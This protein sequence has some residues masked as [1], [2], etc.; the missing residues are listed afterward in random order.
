MELLSGQAVDLSRR[1]LSY[2]I[3]ACDTTHPGSLNGL[4][5]RNSHVPG[6]I[7]TV[8]ERRKIIPPFYGGIGYLVM[9]GS[10]F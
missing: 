1:R 6:S 10:G 3:Q 2:K 5:R 4:K 9:D 8:F 7:V